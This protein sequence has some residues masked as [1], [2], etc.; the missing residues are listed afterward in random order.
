[1]THQPRVLLRTAVDPEALL[2]H[3]SVRDQQVHRA[4]ARM[5][6]GH[7][8]LSFG[9]GQSNEL[10]EAIACLRGDSKDAWVSVIKALYDLNRI[11]LDLT[12]PPLAET[13]LSDSPADTWAGLI[14]LVVASEAHATSCGVEA[15]RGVRSF[16]MTEVT[17]PY[18]VDAAPAVRAAGTIG[19]FQARTHRSDVAEQLLIPLARRSASV[20]IIDPHILE[21]F[22]REDNPARHVE[23][24]LRVLAAELPPGA[25]ISVLGKLQRNWPDAYLGDAEARTAAMIGRA[26]SNRCTPI[27]VD[28]HLVKHTELQN[29]FIWFSCGHSYDVLHNFL[30]LKE[31]SIGREMR[32]AR[33][34]PDVAITTLELAKKLERAG[35]EQMRV[36]HCVC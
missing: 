12:I 7:G 35:G 23:W 16:E 10:L 6:E 9:E 36:T 32:F 18:S 20:K 17:L 4:I 15:D 22:I 34:A 24:L 13:L 11:D 5:L 2:D 8:I 30:P 31:E 14:D 26:L 3:Q 33:Q 27:T 25:H 21:E 19:S 29:R 28:V 1:M